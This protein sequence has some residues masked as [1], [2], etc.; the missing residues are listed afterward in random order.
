MKDPFFAFNEMLGLPPP[1]NVPVNATWMQS[2]H[3]FDA[4]ASAEISD[5]F[6]LTVGVNN[7]TDQE[8]SLVGFSQTQANT[9]PSLYDVLGRRFFASLT[10]K[11]R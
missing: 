2:R 11:V 10:V 6:T 9:D 7:L 8:P 4:A 5:R 3:Y 1:T